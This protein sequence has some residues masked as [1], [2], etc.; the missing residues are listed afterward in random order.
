MFFR[1]WEERLH[2]RYW[3]ADVSRFFGSANVVWAASWLGWRCS[4][5]QLGCL[6]TR[7]AR[8][9]TKIDE[10]CPSC[11]ISGPSSRRQAPVGSESFADI[12]SPVLDANG[13][14]LFVKCDVL[15]ES[16]GAGTR[17]CASLRPARW[18]RGG[19][20]NLRRK[21][22]AA[23]AEVSTGLFWTTAPPI[24]HAGRSF[25]ASSRKVSQRDGIIR[26]FLGLF[27]WSKTANSAVLW[28]RTPTL[29]FS[30]EFSITCTS[31]RK[32]SQHNSPFSISFTWDG[33]FSS[34]WK[35]TCVRPSF[36]H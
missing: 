16:Q 8:S 22:A 11:P 18:Q 28:S 19:Q 31:L 26:P 6:Q 1:C 12:C 3:K 33:S 34:C 30:R 4:G 5:R 29:A 9:P 25:G 21:R 7:H 24:A 2:R 15:Q 23:S 32:A 14:V 13:G 20:R 17:S 10:N 35:R 36:W 27:L